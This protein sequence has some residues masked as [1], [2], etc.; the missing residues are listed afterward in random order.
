[1]KLFP[2]IIIPFLIPYLIISCS[3]TLDVPLPI[4]SADAKALELYNQ[5]YNLLIQ[6][7]WL[8]AK[9]LFEE[10]LTIDPDLILANLFISETDPNKR[11]NYR[12]HAIAN[13]NNGSEAEKLRVNIYVADRDGRLK[14]VVNFSKELVNKYP[15]SSEAYTILGN[16]YTAVQDFDNAIVLYNKA[17]KINSEQFLAWRGL[18]SH[19]VNIGGNLLLPK[20][21]QTKALAL[22]YT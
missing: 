10:A 22:K 20:E 7:E 8:E 9:N 13:N 3:K 2:R 6:N 1:M 12:D 11:K 4:T 15:N 14:D 21:R 16:A 18:A 17:L 5:G 19:Q